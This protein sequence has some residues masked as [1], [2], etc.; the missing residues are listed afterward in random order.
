[1]FAAT[2][3]KSTSESEFLNNEAVDVQ[4]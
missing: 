3:A 2:R 1:M 4:K